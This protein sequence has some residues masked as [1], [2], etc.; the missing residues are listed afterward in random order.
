MQMEQPK[1]L[2]ENTE[3]HV[4]KC[5]ISLNSVT[6]PDYESEQIKLEREC[7]NKSFQFLTPRMLTQTGGMFFDP[8]IGKNLKAR[9]DHIRWFERNAAGIARPRVV[10]RK[11]VSRYFNY[12]ERKI[13]EAASRF[14]ETSGFEYGRE[15]TASSGEYLPQSPGPYTRQ[16]YL[17][18]YWRMVAKCFE[19]YN[20]NPIAHGIVK[21]KT[22]FTIGQGVKFS[23]SDKQLSDF[24]TKW[25]LEDKYNDRLA[26]AYDMAQQ[27][28]EMIRE[29][30]RVSPGKISFVSVDPA[31]IW[32]IIT[33]PRNINQEFGYW[34]Q[35]QTQYQ[36]KTKH[37]KGKGDEK[38]A[39]Y[40]IENIPPERMLRIKFNCH[41]NEKRGRSDLFSILGWLKWAKDLYWH[42]VI[43]SVAESAFVYDHLVDGN[44]ADVRRVASNYTNFPQP[45]S[46]FFHNKSQ[47]RT[48]MGYT[49]AAATRSATGDELINIICVGAGVPK[50]YLGLGDQGS[51]AT[52]VV[53][54]DPFGKQIIRVRGKIE[55]HVRKE[56]DIVRKEAVKAGLLPSSCLASEYEISWDELSPESTKEKIDVISALERDGVISHRRYSEMAAQE[57]NVSNYNYEEEQEEIAEERQAEIDRTPMPPMDGSSPFNPK[58]PQLSLFGDKKPED[59]PKTMS[60]KDKSDIK[61]EHRDQ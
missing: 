35:Y 20:H 16:L 37:A 36:I 59:K 14:H 52:A 22:A 31:T 11:N 42:K 24:M 30:W 5:G 19:A 48:I 27:N 43:R 15:F 7:A 4:S 33:N 46:I 2:R 12:A 17:W 58:P 41:E 26:D 1:A 57:I 61:D 38:T 6:I 55:T 9:I 8:Q 21:I 44:A 60:K 3:R 49:G 53:A 40:V 34:M 32:E 54:T 45:G 18:D 39:D 25:L 29:P 47:A 10:E 51:R 50:E 28:G 13:Q 56:F 23:S